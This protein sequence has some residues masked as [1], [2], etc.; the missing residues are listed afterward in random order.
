MMPFSQ[1][2]RSRDVGS[3]LDKPWVFAVYSLESDVIC[4][5]VVKKE[6]CCCFEVFIRGIGTYIVGYPGH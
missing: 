5:E 2:S 6:Q 4:W 3:W 1:H